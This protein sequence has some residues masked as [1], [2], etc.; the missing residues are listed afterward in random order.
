MQQQLLQNVPLKVLLSKQ[1]SHDILVRPNTKNGQILRRLKNSYK[2]QPRNKNKKM[3]IKKLPQCPWILKIHQAGTGLP[4]TDKDT[5]KTNT[6]SDRLKK[7]EQCLQI[8]NS[9]Q[10][11]TDFRD[12]DMNYIQTK[13]TPP[14]KKK[15]TPICPR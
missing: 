8:S 3:K 14:A 6:T 13:R 15:I 12:K 4:G 7:A 2:K 10:T 1:S 9:Y 5:R 11:L